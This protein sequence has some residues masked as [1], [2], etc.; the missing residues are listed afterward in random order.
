[1][2]FSSLGDTLNSRFAQKG[3][4][5]KQLEDSQVVEEAKV[6]LSEMF[7]EELANTAIPLFLKNR[8]LTISCSSSAMAQE[9]R[10]NQVQIVDKLNEKLG[11]N[12]VD[13]IRYLA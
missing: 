4:L 5:K 8:T 6:V 1:M 7:G 13:R 11:R 2:P 12:E 3:P 10:L 9:I